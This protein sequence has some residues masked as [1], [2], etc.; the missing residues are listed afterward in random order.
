ME[1][2]GLT[3]T[4]LGAWCSFLAALTGWA[5]IRNCWDDARLPVVAL[6]AAAGGVTVALLRSVDDLHAPAMSIT[7]GV[8][9]VLAAIALYRTSRPRTPRNVEP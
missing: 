3:G 8:V 1:L 7:V 2:R 4:Y 5:A 9:L 6:G